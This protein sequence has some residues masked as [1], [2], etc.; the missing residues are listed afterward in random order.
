MEHSQVA[1][2]GG[3]LAPPRIGERSM[4]NQVVLDEDEYTEGLSHIIQ[5][6]F[7]PQLPRLRAENAYLTALEKG[8]EDAVRRTARVL[9]HE[10]KR[11]EMLEEHAQRVRAGERI[12]PMPIEPPPPDTPSEATPWSAAPPTR[13]GGTTPRAVAQRTPSLR[14]NVSI[15]GYLSRYTSEDNASFAQIQQVTTE[16]RRRHHAWAYALEGPSDRAA[17]PA[18][19]AGA[20][21]VRD[22]DQD[23]RPGWRFKTRNSLMFTPD[24]D[25]STLSQR[26]SSRGCPP[27][28]EAPPSITHMNTRMSTRD[29][30]VPA[31]DTPSS[32]VLDAAIADERTDSPRVAGFGFVT[33]VGRD[34]YEQRVQQL[35]D[36]PRGGVS[37]D[38]DDSGFKIPPAPQREALAHRLAK[39]TPRARTRSSRS[40]ELSPAARTLLER[41]RSASSLY[42]SHSRATPRSSA[43]DEAH[44]RRL[45]GKRWTPTPSP[46]REK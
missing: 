8:D 37:A 45:A 2:R 44:R 21:V 20:L 6:D 9:A 23:T 18:P 24:V 39:R 40:V 7:F 26:T 27:A 11:A 4:R 15:D 22:K 12:D 25:V 46:I 42:A 31:P 36:A 32:S 1:L 19:E 43:V 34:P 28:T 13:T 3:A 29:S 10:E 33:P 35:V 17:L 30:A 38:I 16:R 14:T 41:T 5:R